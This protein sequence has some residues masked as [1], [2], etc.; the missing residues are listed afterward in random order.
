MRAMT[1]RT[2]WVKAMPDLSD[3]F[4]DP[5]PLDENDPEVPEEMFELHK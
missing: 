3:M 4:D 1:L 2:R 5:E